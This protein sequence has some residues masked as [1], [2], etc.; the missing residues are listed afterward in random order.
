MPRRITSVA[1]LIGAESEDHFE[2]RVMRMAK[3]FGWCGYHIRYSAASVRGI[4]TFA[5]DGHA[6]GYGFPDWLFVKPGHPPKY[7]E[8]KTEHGHM[9][10]HQVYW[11]RLLE[12]TGADVAVWRPSMTEGIAAEFAA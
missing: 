4:H 11:H 9:S 8:L 6:C 3:L 7:R 5:R 1:D 12:A 2:T 10:R